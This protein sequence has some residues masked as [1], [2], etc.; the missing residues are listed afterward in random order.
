MIQNDCLDC[1]F[2]VFR[3]PDA[4][5]EMDVESMKM[6][7]TDYPIEEMTH[8]LGSTCFTCIA[9]RAKRAGFTLRLT[10]GPA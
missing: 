3:F 6:V 8:A 7:F 2:T 9:K 10:L 5:W 1:G 4:P